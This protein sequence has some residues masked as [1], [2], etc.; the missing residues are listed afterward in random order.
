MVAWGCA[1]AQASSVCSC[2]SSTVS[3]AGRSTSSGARGNVERFRGSLTAATAPRRLLEPTEEHLDLLP[4]LQVAGPRRDLEPLLVRG[5]GRRD[6]ARSLERATEPPVPPSSPAS[7]GSPPGTHRPRSRA[8]L[9]RDT[10]RET[11]PHHR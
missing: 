1:F 4:G 5:P 10:P 7:A 9:R 6:L 3:T 11:E 8:S 2:S